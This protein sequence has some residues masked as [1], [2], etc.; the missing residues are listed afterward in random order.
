MSLA[1][2]LILFFF[3]FPVFMATAAAQ[4]YTS[5]PYTF[6]VKSTQQISV[7]F[8]SKELDPQ[9]IEVTFNI[10]ANHFLANELSINWSVPFVN[11]AGCWTPNGNDARFIRMG[12]VL[13]ANLASQ[14]PVLSLFGNNSD[15]RY[16]FALSDAFHQ[17]TMRA[18]VNEDNAS[19]SCS[20]TILPGKEEKLTSYTIS[21]LLDNRSIAFAQ[22]L[23]KVS[24]WWEAMAA[25]QPSFVPDAAKQPVYST[26]YSYHQRFTESALLKECRDAKAMGYETL[27]LDDGWQTKNPGA[28]YAYTGDWNSERIADM[29]G[30][31]KKVQ[32]TG[33]KFML[34]YSV[35]FMGY[36]AAAYEQFK[37]KYLYQSDRL[38]AAVLDPRYP[39]VRKFLVNKYMEDVRS[40]NLDGLKL[41]FIDSFVN[42]P[43]EIPAVGQDAD[44][45]SLY[46]AVDQLMLDVKKSLTILKPSILI[47]FRQSYIGPAMRKYGNMFRA[48]DC[49]NAALTN[50]VRTTDLK[51]LAGTTAVHAD[52]LMW[53]AHEPAHLAALQ[54]SNVLFAVPQLSVKLAALPAAH[55]N[56]VKFYTRYWIEN[57]AVLLDGT[58]TALNPE[59]NYPVLMASKHGKTIVGLYADMTVPLNVNDFTDLDVVNAKNSTTLV[60]NLSSAIKCRIEIYDCQGVLKSKNNLQLS[61]GSN[62][63]K[64]PLSGIAKLHKIN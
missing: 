48:G 26:W 18:S 12:S 47:E 11:I 4:E 58:F 57:K 53:N 10:R 38:S 55:L 50:R 52:M 33:M 24:S 43:E 3:C 64:V 32:Q 63:L 6:S 9:L 19:L 5:G 34:W 13:Q 31:V 56:M 7:D 25:Y 44:F 40:W 21:I 28:G 17:S 46:A 37:G 36:R 2:R 27:I 54:F 29:A 14:A 23:R 15:N 45:L 8:T 59:L 39:Q 60:L 20:A 49:P 35:P 62:G 42:K 41:D 30:F 16:T 1:F 61:A 22:S 51:L